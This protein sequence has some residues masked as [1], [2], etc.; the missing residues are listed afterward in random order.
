MSR[1]GGWEP[2]CFKP[3]IGGSNVLEFA[4]NLINLSSQ[5][6]WRGEGTG[7]RRVA[8]SD[9]PELEFVASPLGR[10]RRAES[11]GGS[12]SDPGFIANDRRQRSEI[13]WQRRRSISIPMDLKGMLDVCAGILWSLDA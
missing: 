7:R 4:S 2:I 3:V 8:R 10:L 9:R 6:E 13:V 12:R 1:F 5:V 11:R